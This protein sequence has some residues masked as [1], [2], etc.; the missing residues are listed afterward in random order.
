LITFQGA[1]RYNVIGFEP[2]TEYFQLDPVTGIITLKKS[3]YDNTDPNPSYTVRVLQC[4]YL[5]KTGSISKCLMGTNSIK[6]DLVLNMWSVP[7]IVTIFYIS[8]KQ[9]QSYV[10]FTNY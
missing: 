3:L 5:V 1:V 6:T 10:N 9:K 8:V 4:N 2:G 7:H